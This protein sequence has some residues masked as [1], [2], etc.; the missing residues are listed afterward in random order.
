MTESLLLKI[1][2]RVLLLLA[3]ITN[4]RQQVNLFR[5][6]NISLKAEQ[7]GYSKRLQELLSLLELVDEEKIEAVA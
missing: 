6:E 2:E 3:E 7:A 1:E 4:L 5:Q